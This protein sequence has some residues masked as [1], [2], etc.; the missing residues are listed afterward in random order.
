[1][2]YVPPPPGIFKPWSMPKTQQQKD[3][4]MLDFVRQFCGMKECL[5][6]GKSHNYKNIVVANGPCIGCP[7]VEHSPF[8]RESATQLFDKFI[9]ENYGKP[10]ANLK[11]PVKVEL[12]IEMTKHAEERQYRHEE[13]DGIII[14]DE[15]IIEATR[16]G[17]EPIV[18]RQLKDF[19]RLRDKYWLF[20]KH[21]KLRYLNVIGEFKRRGN[22]LI[23]TIITVMFKKKFESG[24][25]G[26]IKIEI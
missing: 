16:R 5:H 2:I 10:I 19:D 26:E 7:Y 22:E 1:M 23:F 18:A 25:G 12:T 13:E 11:E 14:S 17:L 8:I 20:D 9:N 4:M 15:E 3:R 24:R 6:Q 21:G